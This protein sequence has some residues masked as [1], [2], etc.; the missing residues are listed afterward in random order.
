MRGFMAIIKRELGGYFSTPL[1]YVFIAIFL[2]LMGVSTF[3]FGN[4]FE[5]EQADLFPFFTWHPWLYLFLI[6]AI[7]MRLWAEERKTGT[8]EFLFTQPLAL[9]QL[10]LGKFLAAWIFTAIAL[11]LSFPIWITVNYLGNPD[12]G[13]ILASYL[14]SLLMAAGYLAISLCIS[15]T[16]KNQVIAFIVSLVICFIFTLSG[17]PLILNLFDSWLPQFLLETISSFSFLT[18]FDSISK[19]VLEVQSI[20]YFVLLTTFWL[21]L[22]TI[23]LVHKKGS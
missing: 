14:G 15:A 5:R 18:N 3:Y 6:P 8:I 9:W 23:V 16:T 1:A 10:V 21:I 13:I 11:A 19:G 7:S 2:L 20:V 12:N 4:F 22:N 17:Y